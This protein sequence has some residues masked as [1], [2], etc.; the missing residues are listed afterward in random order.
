[1]VSPM[2]KGGYVYILASRHNGTLYL[3]V[4]SELVA[5]IHK[6]RTS[7]TS[8]F[9]DRYSV[10]RLVYLDAHDAIE[11]AISR[12][13]TLKRWRRQWKID[14]IERDNPNWR[15]LWPEIVGADP[16]K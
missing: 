4:T 1:M 6:H 14:L 10:K 9:T 12:E 3:G 5:R 13:K 11:T 16:I 8:G 15:D 2:E 7:E